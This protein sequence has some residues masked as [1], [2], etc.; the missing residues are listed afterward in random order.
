[1]VRRTNRTRRRLRR[2]PRTSRP[3]R[4]LS[5]M[6]IQGGKTRAPNNPTAKVVQPWNS[7]I[8]QQTRTLADGAQ[9]TYSTSNIATAIIDHLGLSGFTST[10]LTFRLS[11]VTI[12]DLASRS[13]EIR[14]FD[15]VD[16]TSASTELALV[17]DYP[18]KN[19]WASVSYMWPL[20]CRTNSLIA[21]TARCFTIYVGSST[22]AEFT[23]R[24]ILVEVYG[25]WVSST[26]SEPGMSTNSIPRSESGGS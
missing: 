1:M 8:I 16:N 10:S 11:R 20:A 19:S 13:V 23:T 18:G 5:R 26:P 2:K 6:S 4:G 7:F 24:N 9:L 17:R 14:T 22:T 25:T 15:V 3:Q 12:T 21:T